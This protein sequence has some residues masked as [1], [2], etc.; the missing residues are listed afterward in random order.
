[1]TLDETALAQALGLATL[2]F[3]AG[4]WLAPG[5]AQRA[6]PPASTPTHRRAPC[7]RLHKRENA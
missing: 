2:V 6:A 3:L 7:G 1:M 4:F 5:G